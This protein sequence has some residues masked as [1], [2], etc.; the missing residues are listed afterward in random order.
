MLVLLGKLVLYLTK[1]WDSKNFN[2]Q[3]PIFLLVSSWQ[4]W[5]VNISN[6][7]LRSWNS[8]GIYLLKV[9]NTNIFW[10]LFYSF[11]PCSSVSVVNFEHVIAGWV[12]TFFTR[13]ILPTYPYPPLWNIYNAATIMLAYICFIPSIY[14]YHFFL[15]TYV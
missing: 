10:T 9:N 13:V 4:T 14:F 5:M 2:R 11:T 8:S 3:K 15:T 6:R 1:S 12:N 7:L